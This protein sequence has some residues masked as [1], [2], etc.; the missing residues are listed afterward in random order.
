MVDRGCPSERWGG[1]EGGREGCWCLGVSVSVYLAVSVSVSA[2]GNERHMDK[3]TGRGAEAGGIE[4]GTP[5]E[6]PTS[7]PLKSPYL[8][9]L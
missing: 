4:I 2:L 1:T 3:R 5:A 7:L 8:S 9:A 6:L